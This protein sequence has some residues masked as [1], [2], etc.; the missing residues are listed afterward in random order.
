[1]DDVE[2]QGPPCIYIFVFVRL[3]TKV[4]FDLIMADLVLKITPPC[5]AQAAVS[6]DWRP[7]PHPPLSFV[8]PQGSHL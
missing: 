7:L 2:Y 6:G 3:K 8:R 5:S 4:C 1:M